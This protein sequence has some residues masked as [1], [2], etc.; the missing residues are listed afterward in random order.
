MPARAAAAR[1]RA[2]IPAASGRSGR[3]GRASGAGRPKTTTSIISAVAALRVLVVR[4]DDALD[5]LV[6]HDVLGT[7]GDELDVVEL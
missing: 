3:A 1:D 4:L 7:E 2:R 5:E 6:A